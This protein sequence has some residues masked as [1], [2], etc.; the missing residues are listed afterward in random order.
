[1]IKQSI[2]WS[3]SEE[4]VPEPIFKDLE[5]GWQ[6]LNEGEVKNALE[7]MKKSGIEVYDLNSPLTR[8]EMSD[9]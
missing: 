6:L 5:I 4:R 7:S 9:G 2:Y 8:E 1:M 3:S